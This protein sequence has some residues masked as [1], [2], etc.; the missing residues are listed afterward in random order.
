M[1]LFDIK[2]NYI[3]LYSDKMLEPLIATE[4]LIIRN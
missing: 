1:I 2:L 4:I 3:I